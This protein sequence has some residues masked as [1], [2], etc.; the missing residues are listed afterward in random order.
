MYYV[1]LP[2]KREFSEVFIRTKGTGLNFAL[3]KYY[4][5]R[6]CMKGQCY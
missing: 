1:S 2:S 3:S 5:D 6:I 4:L